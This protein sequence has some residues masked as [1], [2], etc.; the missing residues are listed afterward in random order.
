MR[1]KE[2]MLEAKKP[3][4]TKELHIK[5]LDGTITV[6]GPTSALAKDAQ[7]M[8]NGDAYLVFECVKDPCLKSKE[9]QEAFGCVEPLEIVEKLFDPGEIPQISVEC[10][11]LS[12]YIDGVRAVEETKN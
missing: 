11:R 10:L 7:E 1:R 2:Q 5:S 3:P 9:L 8:D 4:K 6:E 12:G